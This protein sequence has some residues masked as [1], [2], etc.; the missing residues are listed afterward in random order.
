MWRKP[1]EN[2]IED[3]Q[4][5][6]DWPRRSAVMSSRRFTKRLTRSLAK[7]HRHG[8]GS[9]YGSYGETSA[10]IPCFKTVAMRDVILQPGAKTMGP[11]MANAMV[12][13]IA[14]G[15]LRGGARWQDLHGQEE[16]RLDL[17]RGDKR[18]GVQ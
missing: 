11:P 6:S 9:L 13:H 12:C 18:A 8:Q 5:A 1:M 7:T 2:L 10:I 3:Q 16:L 17:Q 15:E 4:W 14:E